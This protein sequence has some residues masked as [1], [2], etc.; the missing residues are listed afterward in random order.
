VVE[1]WVG[2]QGVTRGPGG[3]PHRNPAPVSTGY[4]QILSIG[5]HSRESLTF[6]PHLTGQAEERP[7][8]NWK[9]AGEVDNPV[10]TANR[11]RA[12]GRQRIFFSIDSSLYPV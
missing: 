6:V 7:T 11:W 2:D 5:R 10:C 4:A 8:S 3:P 1:R 12:K 9:R